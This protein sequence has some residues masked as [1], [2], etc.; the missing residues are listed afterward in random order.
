MGTV[1]CPPRVK[2]Q[3]APPAAA[4]TVAA[5]AA[6]ALAHDRRLRLECFDAQFG[7]QRGQWV[8]GR[9][10][11]RALRDRCR[12]RTLHHRVRFARVERHRQHREHVAAS[13]RS[14]ELFLGRS[15]G[16][17]QYHRLGRGGVRGVYR[18]TDVGYLARVDHQHLRALVARHAL[19]STLE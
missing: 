19:E 18:G 6:A 17:H 12:E 14:A 7:A 13:E 2:Y 8:C 1:V 10:R 15:L 3:V 4:R 16:E 9:R 11:R 5:A